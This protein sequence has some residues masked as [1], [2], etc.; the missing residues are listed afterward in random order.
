MDTLGVDIE[1]EDTAIGLVKF[2]RKILA[3]VEVTMW[4]D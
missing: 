1:V 4:K 3:N 2:E